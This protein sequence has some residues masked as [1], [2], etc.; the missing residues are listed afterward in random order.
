[1]CRAHL[2]GLSRYGRSA[3]MY[4]FDDDIIVAVKQAEY[5][6]EITGRAQGILID[7]TVEDWTPGVSYVE[8]VGVNATAERM[9]DHIPLANPKAYH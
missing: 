5:V 9:G 8:T 1:M 6:Y 2:S 7:L 4:D 3:L